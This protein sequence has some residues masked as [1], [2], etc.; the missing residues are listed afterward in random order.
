MTKPESIQTRTH[1]GA[2]IATTGLDDMALDVQGVSTFADD[3][4][5]ARQ[6]QLPDERCNRVGTRSGCIQSRPISRVSQGLCLVFLSLGSM[7]LSEVALI[8]LAQSPL[9]GNNDAPKWG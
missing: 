5:G 3:V 6:F 1:D 9:L 8:T 7:E 4:R 2:G